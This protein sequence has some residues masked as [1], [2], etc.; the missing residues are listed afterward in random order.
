MASPYPQLSR[1]SQKG[2]PRR[3]KRAAVPVEVIT[4][5]GAGNGMID[6]PEWRERIQIEFLDD[7][8]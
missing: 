6:D 8:R 5:E 7:Q 1:S 4:G 2:C 3:P